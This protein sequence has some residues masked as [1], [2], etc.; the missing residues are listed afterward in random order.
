MNELSVPDVYAGRMCKAEVHRY[1][2][3]LTFW[4]PTKVRPVIWISTHALFREGTAIR[5]GVPICFPWFAKGLSS[6][7]LPSHGLARLSTWERESTSEYDDVVTAVYGLD[8]T[9][10]FEEWHSPHRNTVQYTISMGTAL[11]LRLAVTNTDSSDFTFEEALHTYLAV[12]DINQVSVAG[13]SGHSYRDNTDGLRFIQEG[14][15]RFSGEVDRIYDTSDTIEVID[16]GWHRTLRISRVNSSSAIV[17]NPWKDRAT[18]LTDFGDDEWRDMI[19]VE[20]ANVRG[21]AV[22]IAPGETH[23]MGYRIDVVDHN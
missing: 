16:P 3:N 20:G 23:T 5:G 22:T 4:Q 6:D 9:D 1:G 14:P 13:L 17:W 10:A 11:D 8:S 19:C 7:R 2:A 15:L 18:E 21:A 12:S